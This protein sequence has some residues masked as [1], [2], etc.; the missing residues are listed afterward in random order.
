MWERVQKLRKDRGLPVSKIEQDVGFSNGSLKKI[1]EKTECGRVYA[2]AK[3]FGVSMEYLLTGNDSSGTA[4][5]PIS[6]FEYEIIKAFR[7]SEFQDAVLNLL[8]LEKAGEEN[9]KS[10]SFVS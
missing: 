7:G 3:Y 2:L 10:S 8:G 4:G 6:D 5:Y 9:K 1:S